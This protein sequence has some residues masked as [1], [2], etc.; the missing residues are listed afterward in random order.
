MLM[1]T[2]VIL[3][4]GCSSGIGFDTVFALKKRGHRV[5]ASCRKTVDVQKLLSKGIEALL[6]DVSD[7]TSIQSAFAQL[8]IMTSGRLDILINNAGYGQIGALEDISRNTLRQQFETNVFGLHELTNLAIPIMRQQGEGRIINISS[9]LGLISM[10]FRGAYNSSKYAL[11][12]MSDTL[13]LELSG[14]GIKV[15]TIEPGPIRSQFR[16]NAVDFSL[17]Q[18]E[19]EKSY[20]KSQYKAMLSSFKQKKESSFFTQDTGAVIK[21]LIHAIESKKPQPKYP[22]TTAAH[23]LIG[24]KRFLSTRFLDK[25]ILFLSRKELS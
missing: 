19:I 14:S 5:I 23:F 15:I 20:F 10:P 21:K 1:N 4:T 6:L 22:V 8:L 7:T 2:K 9:I 18:I 13:R 24:L 3:I 17:Q 11:E 16:D 12:G 25:V